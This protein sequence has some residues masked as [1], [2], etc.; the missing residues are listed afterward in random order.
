MSLVTADDLSVT[1]GS[2]VILDGESF[3]VQAGEKIGL[4]GPNGSGKS[5]LLRILAGEREAEGGEVRFARGVRAGYLPQDILELPPG[6]LC[7]SVRAAVPGSD[8]IARS[9]TEVEGDLAAASDGANG[10]PPPEVLVELAQRLADLH[11]RLADFEERYGRHRAESIL[12]GLGFAERDFDRDVAELSGGWKMRAALAGLL[13]LEPELLLLDEPTNHLDIPSLQ[14]FDAFLRRSPTAVILV[15]HDRDFLNRQLGNGGRVLSFEPEGL[16]SYPGDYEAYRRQRAEEELNLE[17]RARRQAAERAETEKFI[18][19]FRYKASKARQVQSRIKQLEKRAAIEVREQRQTVRF[20]F[21]EVPRSGREVV[22]LDGVE[23]RF[24]E[25]VIYRGL[26][27]T[28]ERGERVAIIG[29]NGAGKTTLLKLIAGELALDG[30]TITLG[31]NVQPAYYAQHHTEKLDR[32]KSIL[33][34]IWSLVPAESQSFVRGVLGSFLFSGDDVDKKIAVLSGGERA[35]VA[36]A[37]LLVLPSNLILMDEP[38]NHLDLDSSERLVEALREYGG[39]LLFVSHNRSFINQLATRIWDVR[40]G[41]I[42][43]WPGNLDAWLYHL[44]QIGAA[45]RGDAKS[46]AEG[47]G[48]KEAERESDRERRKREAR[49]REARAKAVRPI[50]QELEKLERRIAEMEAEKSAIEPRL[51]DPALYNDFA[52]ARP[53]MDRFQVLQSKLEELYG[54]WEHLQEQLAGASEGG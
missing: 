6:T 12:S 17:V 30:G 46:E 34:E 4:I 27:R 13:L 33:D 5:T 1:F 54:R 9:I 40:D 48:A 45:G 8:Q 43:E 39:T 38:T 10:E 25:K 24:G 37:R 11:H 3:A 16:R 42:E 18:E 26:T 7:D 50:K 15:S 51:A 28:L 41:T 29:V 21:P 31:H 49:E 32:D 47:A 19:R 22:R 14:W 23:K 20:H 2:K 44:D 36:L 52:R 35:R 53:L